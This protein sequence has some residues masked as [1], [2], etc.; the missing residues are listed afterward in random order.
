MT[1]LLTVALLE[2]N[3]QLS[4]NY[5]NGDPTVP[6][7]AAT[8]ETLIDLLGKMRAEFQPPRVPVD[9]QFGQSYEAFV[10]PRWHVAN[11]LTSPSALISIHHPGFGWQRFS[12]PLQSAINFRSRLT[13][14]IEAIQGLQGAGEP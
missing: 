13:Q 4:I 5:Q 11:A 7:S 9:P 2:E 3:G 1:T 6:L 10:D 12:L 14:A 8:L